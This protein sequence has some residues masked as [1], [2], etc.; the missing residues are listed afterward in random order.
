MSPSTNSVLEAPAPDF[1]SEQVV[2]IVSR[3]FGI[4]GEARPLTTER[5]QNFY[6]RSLE[7]DRS[8]GEHREYVFK[9]ANPA[10]DLPTLEPAAQLALQVVNGMRE[11]GVLLALDGP[12]AN[13]L[14]IRPPLTFREQPADQL[15]E[16]LASHLEALT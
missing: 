14:K 16:S 6:I 12:A 7:P 10:E 11:D 9:I 3:C 2:E 4:R 8:S 15:I 5:D 13:V 1:S